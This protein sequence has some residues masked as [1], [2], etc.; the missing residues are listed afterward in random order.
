[1]HP[2]W[3]QKIEESRRNAVLTFWIVTFLVV[4]LP[5]ILVMKVDMF[6]VIAIICFAAAG[7][8]M[9]AQGKSEMMIRAEKAQERMQRRSKPEGG[10]QAP[11]VGTQ[12][13]QQWQSTET[14]SFPGP[15]LSNGVPTMPEFV[16]SQVLAG[17]PT[18]PFGAGSSIPY[19]QQAVA[20]ITPQASPPYTAQTSA[21]EGLW[22]AQQMADPQ[23]LAAQQETGPLPAMP[24]EQHPV[25]ARRPMHFHDMARR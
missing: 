25:H 19:S 21:P 10:S 13:G 1:M 17:V 20:P 11:E 14:N 16:G 7:L 24:V 4:V 22:T 18:D 8:R 2:Y 6:I 12:S 3:I 9:F 15:Q 5:I 23:D